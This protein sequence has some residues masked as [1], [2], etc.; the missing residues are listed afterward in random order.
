MLSL[1]YSVLRKTERFL[2]YYIKFNYNMFGA[3]F[4]SIIIGIAALGSTESIASKITNQYIT[5]FKLI[6]ISEMRASGIPASI[7]LA[8]GI[9]E[10]D[11]GRSPLATIANNHFG[12][13][14]GKAWTG[15]NI[16]QLDDDV[17]STGAVIPS[18]FRAYFHGSESYRDHTAFLT[19]PN[20][21]SRYGFLFDLGS[22]DYQGWA[23]GLKMAGYA[24]D[25][26]YPQKLIQIIEKFKLYEYD[27]PIA[28]IVPAGEVIV[29]Q[30]TKKSTT[31]TAPK[32]KEKLQTEK[33]KDT[34]I[35]VADEPKAK[36]VKTAEKP[37]TK[38]KVM[39]K[40]VVERINGLPTVLTSG[41]ESLEDIATAQGMDPFDLLSFN[42]G[43]NS[44][45]QILGR[46][47]IVFLERKKKICETRSQHII[48]GEET[49]YDVAQMY[50]IRLES[51]LKMNNLS[52]NARVK[53][54][55]KISLDRQ[56]ARKS[57]PRHND[58]ARFDQ[59][60]NLG[61]DSK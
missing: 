9:L 14:C 58:V 57:T 51:L 5:D 15:A 25:P 48:T 53:A 52:Q 59:F 3:Q 29:A 12:V 39:R 45:Y 60:L 21:K 26:T 16:M 17:D 41:G 40:Y 24:S 10:S 55:E 8:Q 22:A 6:S 23:H 4:K 44:N 13:K 18:C 36:K 56:L 32:P 43:I 2:F 11:C 37:N 38:T 47:T 35:I 19:S 34:P 27:E 20:K 50:G 30:E 7:K 28:R 49:M 33:S 46:N 1:F 54:G 61:S 42:E 31:T